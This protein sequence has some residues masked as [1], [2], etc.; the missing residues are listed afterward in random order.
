MIYDNMELFSQWVSCTPDDD[1][2]QVIYD[3]SQYNGLEKD[4]Q[5]AWKKFHK[6]V[7]AFR[8]RIEKIIEEEKQLMKSNNVPTN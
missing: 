8:K 7:S 1:F 5:K 2:F 3:C 6:E 4:R